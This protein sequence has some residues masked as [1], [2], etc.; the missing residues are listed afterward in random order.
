MD[1]CYA[2]YKTLFRQGFGYSSQLEDLGRYYLGYT[3]L[4]QHWSGKL[5]DRFLTVDYEDLVTHQEEV[6]RRIVA[7]C[8]L[9]WEDAC[10][11]FETNAG[12][13]LTASA[14]QVRMPVYTTSV[15]LW[16]HY[17]AQLEPLARVLQ[18]GGS[19]CN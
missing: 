15:G 10:L 18:Q 17:E 12:P 13:A 1:S 9:E 5:G 3:D 8:G 11:S 4:M 16:R 19:E 2:V 14:A 7:F 6:S